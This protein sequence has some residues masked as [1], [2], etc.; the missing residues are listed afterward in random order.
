VTQATPPKALITGATGFV[1]RH[2]TRRLAA[3][4]W[5]VDAIV[6][7]S[8]DT[9]CLDGVAELGVH[10]CD[11]GADGV[12]AALA[13]SAPDVVFH[14]A[15]HYVAEHSADDIDVLVESNLRF[16]A[17]VLQAAS[18]NGVRAFVNA[19][20][21]WQNFND[22]AYR[23]VNFYA[24]T[25]QAFEDLIAYYADA[26]GLR[27]ATLRLFDTY[28]PDD[29]RR[30]LFWALRNAVET[31]IAMDMSPGEQV[32]DLLYVDDA[33]AAFEMAAKHTL[34]REDAGHAVYGVSGERRSL[35]SVVDTF[36]AVS[37]KAPEVRWGARE[38]REREVMNPWSGGNPVPGWTS[39]ISLEEGIRRMLEADV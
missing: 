21:S 3:H 39:R 34:T 15:T 29:P 27:V 6:R 2:L 35:K 30:K 33:V 24:A 11:G 22:A 16:G 17:H 10:A 37:G 23:P 9:R 26:C 13:A 36:A 32:L 4:G 20:T 14:L 25:K 1:G 38:Y 31:G 8:S 19:G 18:A 12:R 5:R 7:P 28:G